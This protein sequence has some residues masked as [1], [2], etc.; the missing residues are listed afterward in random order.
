VRSGDDCGNAWE[1]SLFSH[2]SRGCGLMAAKPT[3]SRRH[4]IQPRSRAASRSGSESGSEP[5]VRW[6]PFERGTTIIA[7]DIVHDRQVP[8]FALDVFDAFDQVNRFESM[9]GSCAD[10]RSRIDFVY[11]ITAGCTLRKRLR[12]NGLFPGDR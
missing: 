11:D 9:T 4:D 2:R 8:R 7:R 5:K 6:A 10:R 3:S 1:V 12:S